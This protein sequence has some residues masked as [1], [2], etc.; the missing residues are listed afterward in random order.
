LAHQDNQ[1]RNAEDHDGIH[2]DYPP[3][4]Y[5]DRNPILSDVDPPAYSEAYASNPNT[6]RPIL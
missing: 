1:R 2:P 5:S 6:D 3:P 4:A